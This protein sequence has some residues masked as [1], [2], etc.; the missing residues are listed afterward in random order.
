[1]NTQCKLFCDFYFSIHSKN[2]SNMKSTKLYLLIMATLIPSIMVCMFIITIGNV[3]VSL[4]GI[5]LIA[6]MLGMSYKDIYKEKYSAEDIL[7]DSDIQ[8]IL[9]DND[10]RKTLGKEEFQMVSKPEFWLDF[11]LKATAVFALTRNIVLMQ[12][13][14]IAVFFI[15]TRWNL[16]GSLLYLI[17]PTLCMSISSMISMAFIKKQIKLFGKLKK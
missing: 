13:S 16:E 5:T 9:M 10:L 2:S 7:N 17:F 15:F 14:G 11:L 4:V 1:M 3:Y 12:I 6:T 8:D